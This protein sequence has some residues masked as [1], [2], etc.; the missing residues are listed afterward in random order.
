[1]IPTSIFVRQS[2]L[3]ATV[4]GRWQWYYRL[5]WTREQWL[6]YLD[7][8]E[9]ET[10]VGYLRGAPAGY[11]E[12]EYQAGDSVEIVYFGLLPDF[13]GKGLGGIL[14][15]SAVQRAWDVG[16]RRVW[17]HTCSLDHEVALDNYQARGFHVFKIEQKDVI[18]PESPPIVPVLLP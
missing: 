2:F 7:R 15:S 12:L 4:G 11:F 8:P 5:S 6:A 9:Q 16:A 14:L 17:V 13:I 3:Y 1:M 10:W 18:I